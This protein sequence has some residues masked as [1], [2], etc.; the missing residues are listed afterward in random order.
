MNRGR[1]FNGYSFNADDMNYI[2]NSLIDNSLIPILKMTGA[3]GSITE[4]SSS[5]M[6]VLVSSYDSVTGKLILVF[7]KINDNAYFF[8]NENL[9]FKWEKDK[10]YLLETDISSLPIG[11]NY[12]NVFAELGKEYDTNALNPATSEQEATREYD[13]VLL[14]Y[15]VASS[16]VEA[17]NPNIEPLGMKLLGLRINKTASNAT[18]NGIYYIGCRYLFSQGALAGIRNLKEAI[19]AGGGGG[20]SNHLLLTNLDAG[21]YGTGNHTGLAQRITETRNPNNNDDGND[22]GGL[23]IR[24]LRLAIWENTSTGDI[25]ICQDNSTGGAV[26]LQ[27]VFGASPWQNVS[28]GAGATQIVNIGLVTDRASKIE[29]SANHVNDWKYGNIQVI[30]VGTNAKIIND[31]YGF[32]ANDF[33]LSYSVSNSGS[34]TRLHITNN[35]TNTIDFD[36]KI[37]RVTV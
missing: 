20:T 6:Q 10:Q 14:G 26:W 29:Y 8:N 25:F 11:N 24:C 37:E 19:E 5:N 12:F 27:L 35:E 17:E 23:G 30:I 2:Y 31:N 28:I 33:S 34:D 36:Y 7:R 16:Q 15:S 18:I 1:Y 9:L 22:T 21:N 4:I 3:F 32:L 13:R